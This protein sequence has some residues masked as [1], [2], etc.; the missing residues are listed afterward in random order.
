MVV[1]LFDEWKVEEAVLMEEFGYKSITQAHCD[2]R[3]LVLTRMRLEAKVTQVDLQSHYLD[4]AD[5]YNSPIPADHGGE[6]SPI[7]MGHMII[8]SPP[9]DQSLVGQEDEDAEIRDKR[10]VPVMMT[11]RE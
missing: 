1:R 5:L 3:H 6:F 10:D 2:F 11:P 7:H 8:R 4:E 9:Q